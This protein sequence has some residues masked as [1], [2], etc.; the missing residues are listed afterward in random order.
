MDEL[1]ASIHRS[2]IEFLVANELKELA[3]AMIDGEITLE[4][5]DNDRGVI[6]INVPSFA[7][8]LI[9]QNDDYE[10]P[11]RRAASIASHGHVPENSEVEFRMM[12]R[13]AA[14]DKWKEVARRM[15]TSSGINNQALVTRKLFAR[16]E[17][18]TFEY[19]ELH[20]ASNS[21]IRIAQELEARKVLFFPLAVGVRADTGSRYRDHREVDFLVCEDGV[22]GILEVSFHPDRFEKDAEKDAWFKKSGILC[23]EHRSAEQCYKNPEGVVDEFLEILARH[24]R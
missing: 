20:Y 5:P 10:A 11:L 1:E 3:A 7:C 8:P 23:I 13:D 4:Y 12:L 2:F 16:D 9:M 21:E 22:W 18:E 15:I 19:N 24:K 6:V 17:K 14:D